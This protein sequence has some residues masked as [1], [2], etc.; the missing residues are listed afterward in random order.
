[1]I[2]PEDYPGKKYRGRYCYEHR[3]VYW[4]AHGSLPPIVHHRNEKKRDNASKNLE[5]SSP[6]EHAARHN[7]ARRKPDVI[8]SCG[9][10]GI[11]VAIAG[12]K[13]RWKISCGQKRFFCS[14]SHGAKYQFSG[15][16]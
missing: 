14:R 5:G 12:R 2:A 4:R 16:R 7:R 13:Y 3:L 8:V 15:R 9:W 10:C 1:M 6:S 11:D